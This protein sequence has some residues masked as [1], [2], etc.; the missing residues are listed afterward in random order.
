M[1]DFKLNLNSKSIFDKLF[2]KEVRGY[3]ALEVD[4]FLDYIIEDYQ[5]FD[6]YVSEKNNEIQNMQQLLEEE[7][8]KNH[9]LYIDNVKMNQRLS[10]I[11]PS[12]DVSSDNLDLIKK[13]NL[14]ESYL[15]SIGVDPSKIK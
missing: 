5:T 2:Q 9:R 6:K 12:N 15:F 13:I 4:N 3:N 10:S 14:Y 1:V 8:E 7:K 11:G